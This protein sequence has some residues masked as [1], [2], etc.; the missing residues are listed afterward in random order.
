MEIKEIK[1]K[2]EWEK[3]L[4]FQTEKTFLQSWNWGDFNEKMGS[5]I[6]RVGIYQ[7]IN[8]A[9]LCLVI[10][11]SAKRGR[12]LFVPHGPIIAD[13]F[14]KRDALDALL[15]WLKTLAKSES[16]NFIRLS[17]LFEKTTENEKLFSDFKFIE[18]PMHS[19]AYEATWKLSLIPSEEELL[20]N[21]RKTTRYLIKRAEANN[22]ITIEKTAEVKNIEIYQ[23][24]NKEVSK[25]QKFIGFSNKFIK[26]EF[27]AFS[28]QPGDLSGYPE[29]TFLFGTY[30]NETVA[31]AMVVFW[32]GIAYYHQA[33]SLKKFAKFSIPYL[34]QWEAIKEA[35]KRGCKIYDFW[36]FTDP[37]KFPKHPWAGPTLFKMGF[38]GYK[39]EYVTTQDFVISKKYWIN[40]II[41]KIRKF[42]RGL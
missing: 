42:K 11:I 22:D 35:K 28:K 18:A 20:K 29:V 23:E 10:K 36:G 7:G 25:R 21:M 19:S 8:L 33:A 16:A 12:F 13:G 6:W 5:K 26:N 27:E 31:G 24:L 38:G 15:S 40:Y 34:L 14:S 37:E 32:S 39:T 17:S 4:S 9:G 41:E 30:K 3:F 1:N 2:V